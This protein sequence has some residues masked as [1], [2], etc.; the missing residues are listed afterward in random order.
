MA[1]A[2]GS[3]ISIGV[4]TSLLG[5]SPLTWYRAGSAPTACTVTD[6][7]FSPVAN[8]TLPYTLCSVPV[9]MEAPDNVRLAYT[10]LTTG[11]TTISTVFSA[12]GYASYS[13]QAGSLTVDT[14]S[15]PYRCEFQPCF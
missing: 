9:G 11:T 3:T 4:P 6:L 8:A 14:C 13:F 7:R 1:R 5:S 10:A 2:L 12:V 15:C